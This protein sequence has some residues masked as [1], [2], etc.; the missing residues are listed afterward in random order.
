MFKKLENR[1]KI[2]EFEAIM[3]KVGLIF[4]P[5]FVYWNICQRTIASNKEPMF[6]DDSLWI[7]DVVDISQP[8]SSCDK[9]CI[10]IFFGLTEI[11]GKVKLRQISTVF[12]E[13]LFRIFF[14]AILAIESEMTI[15]WWDRCVAKCFYLRSTKR[16]EIIFSLWIFLINWT[17]LTH[18]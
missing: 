8:V 14:S 17:T 1:Q 13:H 9:W 3:N 12:T 18:W 11:Y 7:V 10:H 16:E 6:T 5:G 4:P 2:A 15:W